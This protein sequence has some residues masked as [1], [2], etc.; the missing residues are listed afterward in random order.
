M[1]KVLILLIGIILLCGCDSSKKE[2]ITIN[3]INC[4]EKDKLV[5]DGAILIDVRASSEYD[6]YHLDDAIN[7]EYTEIANK[8]EKVVDDKNKKIIVYCKSGKRS[9]IAAQSLKDLGY[10]NIYDLGSINNCKK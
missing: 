4:E 5:K 3:K 6:E 1:K 9:D 10:T 7:I 2:E 8:I